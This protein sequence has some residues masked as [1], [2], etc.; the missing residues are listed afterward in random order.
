MSRLLKALAL[1]APQAALRRAYAL[2]ALRYY[3][4][5][6][7]SPR[8][9]SLASKPGSANASMQ[10]ELARLTARAHDLVR[11]TPEAART[12]ELLS[13][14][15]VGTE[16]NVTF[17]TGNDWRDRHIG[18]LWSRW[19]K[20]ADV[21]GVLSFGGL[22]K[23]AV[24]SMFEG[25]DTLVRMLDMPVTTPGERG[26]GL[27]SLRLQV[28]EG[29]QLDITRDRMSLDATDLRIRFGLELDEW[30]R[31]HAFHIAQGDSD[32]LMLDGR[33]LRVPA[34]DICHLYRPLRGG[35]LRGVTVFAPVLLTARDHADLVEA[36]TMKARME[37]CFGLGVESPDA[38]KMTL[39]PSDP[40]EQTTDGKRIEDMHPGMVLYLRPGEKLS[41]VSPT[42]GLAAE[43]ILLAN[44]MRFAAGVNL[45]HDMVSGDLRQ[46]NYSSL[47]AGDRFVRRFVEQFQWLNLVP[48][49][50]DRIVERWLDRA[51]LGGL[52]PDR[53]EGYAYDYVM[54]AREPIDPK[55]DLEADILAVRS[56]RISPQEFISEW[57][58]DWRKVIADLGS[59][60]AELD[61]SP[62]K[63]VLDI[64]PRRTTQTGAAQ[65]Q[66]QT[67]KTGDDGA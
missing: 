3:D 16:I 47:K 39:A 55:K 43:P 12:I 13:S 30:N 57:G 63:I 11:N 44:L 41:P 46:A 28:I 36:L 31:R 15:I 53:R 6:R 56:G 29:E 60:L 21:E 5:A 10:G 17:N 26:Y 20:V 67:S 58:R 22:Q 66:S 34:A 45:S 2:Q 18:E 61:K 54:P 42:G 38:G 27:P 62:Q 65:S 59:F 19:C 14:L 40:N 49:L 8:A 51:I 24:G 7:Q 25:G 33:S 48:M 35:Q 64:D 37:A 52:L 4:G 32:R 23:L 9:N 1:V 50:M